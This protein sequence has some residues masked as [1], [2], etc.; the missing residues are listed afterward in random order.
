MEKFRTFFKSLDGCSHRDPFFTC[1]VC[2]PTSFAQKFFGNR[3]KN[4]DKDYYD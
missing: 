3:C 2:I 4:S 1:A